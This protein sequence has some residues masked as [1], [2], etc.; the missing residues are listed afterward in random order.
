MYGRFFLLV[1]ALVNVG[2][3]QSWTLPKPA[4]KMMKSI[5]TVAGAVNIALLA[6]GAPAFADAIPAVG[7]QISP[8][9]LS[10]ISTIFLA[11]HSVQFLTLT[12]HL[13]QEQMHQTLPC[14]LILE[15]PFH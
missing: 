14:L 7:M 8:P 11:F 10:Q 9:T 5:V 12:V 15:N 6:S 2:L 4:Q 1:V 3:I 13:M